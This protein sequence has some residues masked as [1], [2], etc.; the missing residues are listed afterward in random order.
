[1]S[2][3]A[4]SPR[5]RESPLRRRSR[6][7]PPPTNNCLEVQ[8]RFLQHKN[9]KPPQ[10][11]SPSRKPLLVD[12][13]QP[14]IFVPDNAHA[15][16]KERGSPSRL[17]HMFEAQDVEVEDANTARTAQSA[18]QQDSSLPESPRARRTLNDLMGETQR[19]AML[20]R[21]LADMEYLAVEPTYPRLGQPEFGRGAKTSSPRNG[22]RARSRKPSTL[23]TALQNE[24]NPPEDRLQP[25]QRKFSTLWSLGSLGEYSDDDDDDDNSFDGVSDSQTDRAGC[26]AERNKDRKRRQRRKL[27]QFNQQD[28]GPRIFWQQTTGARSAVDVP[29]RLLTLSPSPPRRTRSTH[30]VLGRRSYTPR[31]RLSPSST[32][33]DRHRSRGNFR[34]PA[35]PSS[36]GRNSSDAAPASPPK[37]HY[38]AWYVPQSEWWTLRQI[39]QQTIADKFPASAISDAAEPHCHGSSSSPTQRQHKP[40]LPP[41]AALSPRASESSENVAASKSARAAPSDSRSPSASSRRGA[42]PPSAPNPLEPQVSSIPQSYIGRE[43]RAYIVSTGSAMPQYLQ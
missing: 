2:H 38:G 14:Q 40:P 26:D 18:P 22:Q 1:M 39:E 36:P 30:V 6:D 8:W 32:I 3:D 12:P 34:R 24:S 33:E 5:H 23:H 21:I 13:L 42:A 29:E 15:S 17:F 10:F 16:S 28:E 27:Q 43:Y 31:Q 19:Q 11:G 25:K 35:G 4:L 9:P 20:D 41:P 7:I 37:A